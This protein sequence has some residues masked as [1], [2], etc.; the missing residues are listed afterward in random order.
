MSSMS[1]SGKIEVGYE[2]QSTTTYT[3][4]VEFS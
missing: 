3:Q 1:F 4:V 2:Y